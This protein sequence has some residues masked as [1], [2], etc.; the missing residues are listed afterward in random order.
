[1][2]TID[3]TILM[4]GILLL[5]MASCKKDNP[6]E[7]KTKVSFSASLDQTKTIFAE[8]KLYWEEGDKIAITDGNASEAV[9][10][11]QE[12]ISE[13]GTVAT[14]DVTTLRPDAKN[15]YAVYPAESYSSVSDDT[16]S[17]SNAGLTQSNKKSF[18]SAAVGANAKGGVVK[19][20]FRNA[21]SLLHFDV[22]EG[23]QVKSVTME[24]KVNSQYL[25]TN[26]TYT[27]GTRS[28][29]SGEGKSNSINF[30]L[31]GSK[32]VNIAVEP[33]TYNGFAITGY[34]SS[35]TKIG[36]VDVSGTITFN[37]GEYRNIPNFPL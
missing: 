20:R 19:L 26:F 5:P 9:T 2:K 6:Q 25:A 11:N 10:L 4:I 27:Y 16:F 17:F 33:G 22:K 7:E 13:G 21:S 15:Y 24:T 36:T 28:F 35:N 3:F 1:M 32:S 8:G 12:N 23:S 29:T 30:E 37:L 18:F 34:D 31:D 14:F